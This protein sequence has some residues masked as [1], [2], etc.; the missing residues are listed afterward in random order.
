MRRT[1]HLEQAFWDFHRANPHVYDR[2]VAMSR[3]ARRAGVSRLGIARLFEVLRWEHMVRTGGDLFK[4]NNNHRSYYARLI[5]DRNPELDGLFQIRQLGADE[6][7]GQTPDPTAPV[8]H[9][10]V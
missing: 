7:F 10:V 3:Q 1:S 4:L 5:M 9:V 6:P 8:G 2:L